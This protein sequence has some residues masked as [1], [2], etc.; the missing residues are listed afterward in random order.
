MGIGQICSGAISGIG[1]VGIGLDLC[2]GL[3][4]EHRFAVLI[5][6]VDDIGNDDVDS[7][8]AN[9]DEV[10]SDVE[11][12]DADDD[13]VADRVVEA[14]DDLGDAE[15]DPAGVLVQPRTRPHLCLV[16]LIYTTFFKTPFPAIRSKYFA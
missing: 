7:D 16:L 5:I 15:D 6:K 1:W 10:D 12:G 11:D 9:D 8:G 4:Y 13:D 14:V 3:L 2:V